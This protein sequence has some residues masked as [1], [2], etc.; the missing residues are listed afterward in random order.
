[1]SIIK[2]HDINLYGKIKDY[3]IRLRP[4][5]DEHLPLLYKWDADPEMTYWLDEKP[6]SKEDV[7]GIYS[8]VSNISYC[9]LIEANGKPIGDCWLEN[10]NIQDRIDMYPGLNVK[11]IDIFICEKDWWRKGIGSGVIGMLTDFAFELEKAD[12]IHI[13]EIADFNER[14]QRAFLRNGYKFVRAIDIDY[15]INAKQGYDYA[16]AKS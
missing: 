10:M 3:N 1:M 11:R 8:Y 16:L 4:L 13:V 7:E 2:T 12:V 15:G 5:C 6:C 14:S 9:F